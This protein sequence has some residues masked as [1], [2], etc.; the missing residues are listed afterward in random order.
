[1]YSVG[2]LRCVTTAKPR[3]A[4]APHLKEIDMEVRL[5]RGFIQAMTW[6]LFGMLLMAHL[7]CHDLGITSGPMYVGWD[8][9]AIVGVCLL[10]F[11]VLLRFD[12]S[13]KDDN[14]ST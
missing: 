1:M 4:K 2:V 7:Y 10:M 13:F 11:Q 6:M 9:T 14:G 8:T 5:V 12:P 3:G